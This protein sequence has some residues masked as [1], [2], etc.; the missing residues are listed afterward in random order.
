MLLMCPPWALG[1][2]VT[3]PVSLLEIL[4]YVA[5]YQECDRYDGSGGPGPVCGRGVHTGDS[6]A[7]RGP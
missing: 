2:L 6:P 1:R 5:E 3:V 4:S 7:L